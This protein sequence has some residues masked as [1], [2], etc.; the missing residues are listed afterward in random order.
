MILVTSLVADPL[1]YEPRI[2]VLARNEAR[3]EAC[4]FTSAGIADEGVFDVPGCAGGL[5]GG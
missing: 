4:V 3:Y 1:E 2:R 5:V